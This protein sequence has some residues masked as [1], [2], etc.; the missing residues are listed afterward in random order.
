MR[1]KDKNNEDDENDGSGS[2][3][4]SNEVSHRPLPPKYQSKWQDDV[5]T[6]GLWQSKKKDI[7][8]EA[9]KLRQARKKKIQAPKANPVKKSKRKIVISIDYKEE[10]E[11]EE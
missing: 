11:E 5:E 3:K 7:V 6:L 10:E 9:S 2:C 8:V 4:E 1:I